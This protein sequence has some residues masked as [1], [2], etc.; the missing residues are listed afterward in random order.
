MNDA[1]NSMGRDS[2]LLA[3]LRL[4]RIPNVFTAIADVMMGYAFSQPRPD[5]TLV[6]ASLISVSCCLYLSGMVLNDVFD[7]EVDKRERPDRPIPSGRISRRRAK[8]IGFSL[9]AAGVCMGWCVRFTFLD[10]SVQP[11]RPGVI[12]TALAMVILLYDGVLKSTPFGPVAMGLCR[13]LNVLLGMSAA[14]GDSGLLDFAL[15]EWMVAGGM[16]IFV[17]GITMFAR[18]E[19]ETSRPSQLTAA[20]GVMV[21]GVGMLAGFP[22]VTAKPLSFRHPA[23]WPVI[24]LLLTLP[25]WRRALNAVRQLSAV[26]VQR[27]VKTSIMTL[28]VLNAG[29]CLATPGPFSRLYALAVLALLIPSLLLGRWVYST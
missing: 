16:G 23:V 19:A 10:A 15:H 26:S 4:L 7:Y 6:L 5:Q 22:A 24:L 13:F 27:T 28:I 29:I 14:P 20:L 25:V 21:L 12:A 11:W 9:L 3:Y 2:Q 18:H 8:V 1:A 17:A